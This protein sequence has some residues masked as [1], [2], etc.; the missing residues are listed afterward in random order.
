MGSLS[1]GVG[2]GRGACDFVIVDDDANCQSGSG[3]CSAAVLLEAEPSGFHDENLI[4]AT[5][6]IREIL[7]GVPADSRGR[8]LSFIQTNMGSL[9]AWMYH[10]ATAPLEGVTAKDDDAT[11]AK[12]LRLKGGAAAGAG[13][14]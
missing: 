12:A 8:K 13:G 6:K 5:Q 10:G 1:T 9:L 14:T 7:A 4:A 3:S 11:I 2:C